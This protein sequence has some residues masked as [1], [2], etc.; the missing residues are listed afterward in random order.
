MLYA[1]ATLFIT[2]GLPDS[3][4]FSTFSHK[5]HDFRKQKVWTWNCVLIFSTTLSET[6][7]ILRGIQPDIIN[8]YWR[9][10]KEP[11]T[12]VSF[13]WKLN[14]LDRFL[15]NTQITNFMKIHPVGAEVLHTDRSTDMKKLLVAFRKFANAPK[16]RWISLHFHKFLSKY[17]S[18]P[19]SAPISNTL[20]GKGYR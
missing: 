14:F 8:A 18:T 9:S 12:L 11:V 7:L 4:S 5:R 2:C 16:K 19:F 1:R 15:K 13:Q 20:V 10:C 6:F 17:G 3:T